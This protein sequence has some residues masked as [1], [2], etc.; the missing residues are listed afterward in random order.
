MEVEVLF[1]WESHFAKPLFVETID[2]HY[3]FMVEQRLLNRLSRGVGRKRSHTKNVIVKHIFSRQERCKGLN[4]GA[5]VEWNITFLLLF[6]LADD[7]I[8]DALV[9]ASLFL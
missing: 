9:R 2:V 3:I 6:A 1:V 4:T 7:W 8:F 5:G